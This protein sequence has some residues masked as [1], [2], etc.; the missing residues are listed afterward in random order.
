MPNWCLNRVT[1]S[2]RNVRI[3]NEII[4]AWYSGDLLEEFVHCLENDAVANEAP[5]ATANRSRTFHFTSHP[6][7]W[8]RWGVQ[9]WGRSWNRFVE[10]NH[11]EIVSP[12]KVRLTCETR[13]S[14]PLDLF[15][16][17]VDLKCNV[18][19]WFSVFETGLTGGYANRAIASLRSDQMYRPAQHRTTSLKVP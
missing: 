12:T 3:I 16:R 2:N 19:A 7:Y 8:R 4:R 1:V 13:W 6:E 10:D 15:D 11:L 18:R 14:P 9:H 17:W 5:N